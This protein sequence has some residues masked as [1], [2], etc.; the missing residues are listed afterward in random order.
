MPWDIDDDW[1]EVASFFVIHTRGIT[2]G[3]VLSSIVYFILLPPESL[4]RLSV[5]RTLSHRMFTRME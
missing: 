2:H 1:N 4:F 3:F 5:I